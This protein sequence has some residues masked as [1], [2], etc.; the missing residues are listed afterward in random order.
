MPVVEH[1]T[2]QVADKIKELNGGKPVSA[3]FVVGGGGKISGYTESLAAQLGIPKERV[4]LRGKKSLVLSVL[5]R[6][7]SR[8]IRLWLLQ[9]V[10]A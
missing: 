9:S 5:N 1:M 8:R 2:K 7:E 4:A 3:V 10:S 6:R